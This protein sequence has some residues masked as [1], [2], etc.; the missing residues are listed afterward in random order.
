MGR[1]IYLTDKELSAL[2][3]SSSEWCEIMSTGNSDSDKAVEDRLENG[4]GSA[5]KKLYKGL[6]GERAYK[7]Y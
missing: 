1:G 4:L 3:D 5:L 2:R 7:D 6:N